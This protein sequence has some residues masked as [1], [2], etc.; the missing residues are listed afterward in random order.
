MS[1]GDRA[2]LT[3]GPYKAW[4]E[5]IA[6]GERLTA[7]EIQQL[8]G[9]HDI[10]SVGMLADEVRRRVHGTRVTF[11]RVAC[12]AYDKP[13]AEAVSPA[14]REVRL[15]GAPSSLEVALTAVH[16][17]KAV[18]GDR[19]LS[20]FSI[21][22]LEALAAEHSLRRV[23]EKLRNAGLSALG[24]FPVDKAADAEGALRAASGAGFEQVRL[25]MAKPSPAERVPA[26]LRAVALAEAF[27]LVHAIS[28]LPMALAA[29]RPT[30]GYEDVKMIAL[31]RLAAPPNTVIQVDWQRYGPKLAQVALTFGANDIDNVSPSDEAP[32][33]R[34]RAPL[35]EVR[36]N[37]E[38]AGFTPAERDGW[39][40]SA[41]S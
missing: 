13:L 20:G 18:A 28:P 36:R 23:L 17:A 10:L 25:T 3:A 19:L 31:A 35:E 40:G 1:S 38:A 22:D 33:G 24:E 6:A 41:G 29:F 15:T 12:C 7:D 14:A 34:R 39:I 21:V 16:S 26:M 27:P 30:T 5:R 2:D 9:E 11:V 37:I 4:S 32:D 8:A